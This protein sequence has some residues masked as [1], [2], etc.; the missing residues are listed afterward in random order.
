M[1][2]KEVSTVKK[3]EREDS[4]EIFNISATLVVPNKALSFFLSLSLSLLGTTDATT[5]KDRIKSACVYTQ[6]HTHARKHLCIQAHILRSSST[7]MR[8]SC[9]LLVLVQ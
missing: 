3:Q 2:N 6:K 1:L 5:S 4:D 9:C 8:E 7:C